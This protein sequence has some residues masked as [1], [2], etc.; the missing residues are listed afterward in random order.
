MRW[1]FRIA[2]IFG[3]DVKLHATFFIVLIFGAMQGIQS[4][5]GIA[6]GV[7][8]MLLLFLC[9]LLHELG[10]SVVAQRF[11]I[12]VREIILLP[13]GGVAV[14][15]RNPATPMQE[16]LVAIAG[17]LVNVIIAIV[18]A[19]AL[20]F[21]PPMAMTADSLLPGATL[22][23]ILI[24]MLAV[25]VMLVLFNMIPA[26]PMDGGRVLRA[27]L[28]QFLGFNKATRIAA[29]VGQIAAVLLAVVGLTGIPGVMGAN[30][31]LL[32]VAFF[33]FTGAGAEIVESQ[34]R[35]VLSTLRVG[36]AYNKHAITLGLDDRVSNVVDHLLTGYQ[37]DF[38]VL[39]RGKLQ[40]VVTREDVL[41]WLGSS[42]YDP[43]VTEVM[44]A[45]VLKVEAHRT[46][47]EVRALMAERQ[48][49]VAAV[50]EGEWFLGLVSI[51][52]IQ[53]AYTVLSFIQRQR[54]G[55]RGAGHP[56]P[57]GPPL[58]AQR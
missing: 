16:L 40:G 11:G 35:T 14:M 41:Q 4:G 38:A 54:E 46:L 58:G 19:L 37:P 22:R 1:A 33:V 13:I 23:G 50:F 20:G 9:V 55:A 48:Q 47:D 49:R 27:V 57:I 42:P 25:N 30:P 29:K 8:F 3:I 51:E 53:E 6:M 15:T 28:W 2:R 45:D 31:M 12:P 18:I 17:P 7:L 44:R 21:M 32:I 26:F 39:L 36:D 5:L 56:G 52:D 34:H 24:S 43:Y 10:H